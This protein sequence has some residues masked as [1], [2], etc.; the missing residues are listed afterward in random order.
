MT[1]LTSKRDPGWL[2]R[3]SPCV[4]PAQAGRPAVTHAGHEHSAPGWIEA[5][6]VI[7][8]HELVLFRGGCGR[9]DVEGAPLDCPADSF[10]IIPPGQWHMS[11]NAGRTSL[12]RYWCHFD[13]VCRGPYGKTPVMTFHP[14]A[15]RP[16][17]YRPAPDFVP[18]GILRGGIRNPVLVYEL[19][20]RLVA[21]VRRAAHDVLVARAVLL[22]L[23]IELLDPVDRIAPEPKRQQADLASRIRQLLDDQFLKSDSPPLMCELLASLGCS[24]EHA[25]RV[26]RNRYGVPPI[27]YVNAQRLSRAR[28]LLRDTDL[29]VQAIA[30][31]VGFGDPTY[32]TALFR[33]TVGLSPSAYRS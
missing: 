14:S 8:D 21:L 15:P 31:R 22:R 4:R 2:L 27:Q 23:L 16:G 30:R 20:E 7:Y 32:F 25:C 17:L 5:L 19:H 18:P 10:I 26:F 29:P 33:K 11:R 3:I 13:W 24:Y 12:H 6:R 28:M 9:V 1:K